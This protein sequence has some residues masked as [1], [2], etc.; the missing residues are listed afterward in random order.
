MEFIQ[1]CDHASQLLILVSGG[2]E[3]LKEGISLEDVME[4]TQR[5]LTTS[6][7]W[8]HD[9]WRLHDPPTLSRAAPSGHPRRRAYYPTE[10]WLP[11][12]MCFASVQVDLPGCAL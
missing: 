12:T 9:S 7:S 10:N 3:V 11:F 6:M 5:P 8:S 4:T 1:G 2:V